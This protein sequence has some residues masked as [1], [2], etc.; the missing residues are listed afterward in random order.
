MDSFG[1]MFPQSKLSD[2]EL[3]ASAAPKLLAGFYRSIAALVDCGNNVI[4]DAVAPAPHVAVFEPL[5]AKFDVVYVALRC[6]VEELERRESVRGDRNIGLARS[7]FPAVHGALRYDIE[8]D[9]HQN[10]T[11]ECAALISQFLAF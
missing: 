6:P 2:P 11:K 10:N 5:F 9:T 7:Q 3:C 4:V 1:I 8:I